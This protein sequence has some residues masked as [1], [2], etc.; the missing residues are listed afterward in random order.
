[1]QDR[2]QD[3]SQTS[4]FV[5]TDCFKE[6]KHI[7]HPN[8]II[9]PLNINVCFYL[10]VG[11]LEFFGVI[12]FYWLDCENRFYRKK[13]SLFKIFSFLHYKIKDP[14]SSSFSRFL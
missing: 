2:S 6:G 11:F 14:S 12:F 7:R 9:V 10:C 3:T 5:Q 13:N 4:Y 8:Y 1:M